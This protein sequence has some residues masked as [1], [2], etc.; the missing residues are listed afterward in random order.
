M[1]S[2]LLNIVISMSILFASGYGVAKKRRKTRKRASYPFGMAGCGLGAMVFED[3]PR[4]PVQTLASTLN[5]IPSYIFVFPTFGMTSGTSN[6]KSDGAKIRVA[7]QQEFLSTN[8]WV[9]AKQ[10][11]QGNGDMLESYAN[12]FG[13]SAGYRSVFFSALQDNFDL[14]YK[15]PGVAEIHSATTGL[16][17]KNPDLRQN[18]Q[19]LF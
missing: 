2:N 15:Q 5:L 12:L 13:C 10:S 4:V 17:K 16:M 6:C 18:C 8:L 19:H 9:I 3:D 14:I 1:R 11:S 7:L